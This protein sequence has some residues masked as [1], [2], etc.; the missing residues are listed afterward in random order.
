MKNFEIKI[1]PKNFA[2]QTMA[3]SPKNSRKSQGIFQ[4]FETIKIKDNIILV[5]SASG[6]DLMGFRDRGIL[7]FGAAPLRPINPYPSTP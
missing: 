5:Q 6:V 4:M 2:K 7:A 3:E 1:G